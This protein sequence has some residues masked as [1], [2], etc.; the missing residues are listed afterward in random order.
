MRCP[1]SS[2]ERPK[3]EL[4]AGKASGATSEPADLLHLADV[5]TE[6]RLGDVQGAAAAER[7]VFGN[8]REVPQAPDIEDWLLHE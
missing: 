6:R 4:D 3:G 1:Y 2:S 8:G 7:P 5:V